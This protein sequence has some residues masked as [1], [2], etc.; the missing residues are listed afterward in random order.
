MSKISLKS[1]ENVY[2]YF[3]QEDC[4]GDKHTLKDR[5]GIDIHPQPSLEH[6]ERINKLRKSINKI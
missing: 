3:E 2:D 4:L 1:D 6:V 5:Y